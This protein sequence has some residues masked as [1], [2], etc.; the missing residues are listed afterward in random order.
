MKKTRDANGQRHVE[1][2]GLRAT[3]L[4]GGYW[5]V[6]VQDNESET[7]WRAVEMWT[8]KAIAADALARGMTP[9]EMRVREVFEQ[10]GFA[11][12][13]TGGNCTAWV[14]KISNGREVLVTA[15]GEPSLVTRITE[16]CELALTDGKGY[17]DATMN[18]ETA[19]DLLVW[20]GDI[21]MDCT[22]VEALD[23]CYA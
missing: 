10:F 17:I 13:Q 20:L 3:P 5:A 19:H 12:E 23:A 18:F 8:T 2:N 6:A 22:T 11:E 9:E 14:I 16:P 7:G 21:T 4:G 1:H 15:S